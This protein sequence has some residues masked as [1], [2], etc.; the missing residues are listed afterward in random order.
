MR[1]RMWLFLVGGGILSF[2]VMTTAQRFQP[3]GSADRVGGDRT[4]AESVSSAGGRVTLTANV[5]IE[6]NGV[7][8]LADRAVIRD[9]EYQLSGNVRMKAPMPPGPR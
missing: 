7:T 9:G 3:S 4:S 6:V 1:H 8:V 2:V 5:V